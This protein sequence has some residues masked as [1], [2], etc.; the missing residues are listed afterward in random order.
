MYLSHEH[1]VYQLKTLS[2]APVLCYIRVSP[3]HR[4]GAGVATQFG[5]LLAGRRTLGVDAGIVLGVDP[6]HLAGGLLERVK[7]ALRA[8]DSHL[9][10]LRNGIQGLDDRVRSLAAACGHLCD[11]YL[12]ERKR[13]EIKVSIKGG[14]KSICDYQR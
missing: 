10:V 12:S 2:T 4:A 5:R 1:E 6:L 13:G 7:A 9:L 14:K 11:T 3:T 8:L